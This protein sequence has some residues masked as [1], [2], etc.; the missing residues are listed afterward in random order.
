MSIAQSHNAKQTRGWLE[1][2]VWG[3]A[4]ETDFSP[5]D[6]IGLLLLNTWMR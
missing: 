1:A 4:V 5:V 6:A 3:K 2:L